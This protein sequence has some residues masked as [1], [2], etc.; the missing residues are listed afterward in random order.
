MIGRGG[1]KVRELSNRFPEVHVGYTDEDKIVVEGPPQD[2]D[3]IRKQLEAEAK[4]L[5]NTLAVQEMSVDEKFMKHIIGKSGANGKQVSRVI[6]KEALPHR[7]LCCT[8]DFFLVV[9]GSRGQT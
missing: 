7:V 4:E 6:F 5:V 9:Q 8:P 2:V 1:E 3:V